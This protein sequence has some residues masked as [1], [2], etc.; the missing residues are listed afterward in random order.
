MAFTVARADFDRI[1]DAYNAGR[2]LT[3]QAL[4]AWRQAAAPYFPAVA[5]PVV[6]DLGCGTGR[7]SV[8]ITGW[9][10]ARVVGL[11]LS[12]EM[13][14]QAQRHAARPSVAY[15]AGDGERMPLRDATCDAAWL[16]TVVH[17]IP[18]LPACARDLRR[19]LRPNAPVFIRSWFPGRA[20]VLTFRYFPGARRI[21][22]TFPTMDQTVAAFAPAGFRMEALQS[23]PQISASSLREFRD[24]VRTRA[25]STLQAISDEE[26]AHGLAA[27]DAEVAAETAPTPVV[28]RLDLLVLR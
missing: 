16:S 7:F 13:L 2:S 24:R 21:A 1:A 4:E 8:A 14:R 25:D 3:P 23:V 11:D 12:L 27:L 9:F 17:H 10:A 6:L 18:D 15:L 19:V 28:D 22:E 20:D 26:F 5:D